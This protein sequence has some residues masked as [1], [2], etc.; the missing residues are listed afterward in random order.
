MS[1]DEAMQE[2]YARNG[3]S[4]YTEIDMQVLEDMAAIDIASVVSTADS[5]LK[6]CVFEVVSMLSI[7]RLKKLSAARLMNLLRYW[8]I[9]TIKQQ[10]T[11]NLLEEIQRSLINAQQD[12]NPEIAF[13]GHSFRKFQDNIYLLKVNDISVTGKKMDWLPASPLTVSDLNIQLIAAESET[14]GLIK[15]LLEKPL[16][17]SFRQGGEKFHPAGRR[18]S[19]SLKKLL[20]E[21][22]IPPWERDVIPLVYLGDELVAVAGLWVCK[23]YSVT[24]DEAGWQVDVDYV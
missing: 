21:A 22:N 7:D 11:R 16:T 17:V 13:Y 15:D 24:G 9:S 3:V 10:P 18:H 12:A 4:S 6:A 2:Y 8:I 5:R 19:Q 14:E 20:Q 1:S 23:K